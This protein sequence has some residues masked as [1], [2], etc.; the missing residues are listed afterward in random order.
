MDL[1]V[2]DLGVAL[3]GQQRV[4]AGQPGL[5][6]GQARRRVHAH[7]L[8]LGGQGALARALLLLLLGQPL[9]LLLQPGRVV[10]LERQPAAAV[11][12]QDP[13]GHVVQEVAVVGHGDDGARVLVQMALQP[14]HGFG[15]QVVGGL[16][17]QQQV[18]L[19]QQ[20]PAQRHAAALAAG[21][22]ADVGVAGRAAQGVHRGVEHGVQ[23]PRV[24]GVDLL[25]ELAELV[26]GLVRVVRGQ[27][28]EAVDQV[29]HGPHAVL[30]V[31][32]HVLGLVQLRAPAPAGPRWRPRPGRPRPGPR[33]PARP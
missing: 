14:G 7:P 4:V 2:V 24:R 26:R 9:A 12:L 18:G 16:V 5:V 29:L 15:V 33:C 21:E 3:L 8:Q 17:K 23:V 20:Q 13:A 6:L 31:A 11:Q 19:A 32:A 30:D 1:H 28:V 25:L 22:L 27:L 10:A